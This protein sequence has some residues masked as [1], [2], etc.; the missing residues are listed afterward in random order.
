[1]EYKLVTISLFLFCVSMRTYEGITNPS[2][3]FYS[4]G[5]LAVGL[6]VLVMAVSLS[7]RICAV[8]TAP[9]APLIW[10][11]PL[12][13]RNRMLEP[14]WASMRRR[15]DGV[16]VPGGSEREIEHGCAYMFGVPISA[17]IFIGMDPD[18]VCTWRL[19]ELGGV[20]TCGDCVVGLGEVCK[21]DAFV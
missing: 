5:C 17:N 20:C 1:M 10:T 11:L 18:G 12:D 16:T 3:T 8:W 6:G 13:W 14:V 19:D 9:N 2:A 21:D 4:W 7:K 15:H